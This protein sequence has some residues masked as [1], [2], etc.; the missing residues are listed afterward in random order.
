VYDTGSRERVP[1]TGPDRALVDVDGPTARCES[2]RHAALANADRELLA[3]T[4]RYLRRGIGERGGVE[5]LLHGE[6][7][8]ANVLT[9]K[10]RA[11][12]DRSR[13]VLP[14]TCRIRPR[15]CARRSQ[16]ALSRC[17]S[18]L[19]ARVP[20]PRAG[21]DHNMALGSRRPTPERAPA[22]HR[23]AQPDPNRARTQRAGYPRLIPGYRDLVERCSWT[24]LTQSAARRRSS[25]RL[26]HMPVPYVRLV[27]GTLSVV[28]RSV[29]PLRRV[30][31]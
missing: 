11:A 20:N 15:P 19:A 29:E 1:L 17:Q 26:R 28:H 6:P 5:Q 9:T 2:R 21:D 7:H 4:L 24:L 22:E 13:D 10:E 18:R 12:V 31:R 25:V 23:V 27:Q 30:P 8:P 16:R 14:W 3:D